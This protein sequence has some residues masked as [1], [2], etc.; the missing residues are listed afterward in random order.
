MNI[1]KDKLPKGRFYPLKSSVLAA[2]F[3]RAG[4]KSSVTL[5]HHNG[6]FWDQRALFHAAF[7][8]P[9]HMVNNEEELIWIGCGSVDAEHCGLARQYVEHQVVPNLVEWVTNLKSLPDGSPI[10]RETQRFE[11]DWPPPGAT[12]VSA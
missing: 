2:A 11:R 5:F 12:G 1:H 7:Y 6:A 3:R 8:P 4:V 9:G 10:R